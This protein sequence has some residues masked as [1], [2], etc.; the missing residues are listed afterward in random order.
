VGSVFGA[1]AF[2]ER[3]AWAAES[4]PATGC[5]NVQLGCTRLFDTTFSGKSEISDLMWAMPRELRPCGIVNLLDLTLCEGGRVSGRQKVKGCMPASQAT[6]A[7]IKRPYFGRERGGGRD[8]VSKEGKN[9][10]RGKIM[11]PRR[12]RVARRYFVLEGEISW[13]REIGRRGKGASAK[14]E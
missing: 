3:R 14:N 10:D 5:G 1:V 2:R 12:R 8:I 7:T 11:S 13:R 4:S 6:K 9:D